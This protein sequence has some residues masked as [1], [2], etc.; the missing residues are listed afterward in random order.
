MNQ[1]S[2]L[3]TPC[4]VA[5]APQV[6]SVIVLKFWSRNTRGHSSDIS[7]RNYVISYAS[8]KN[9][10]RHFKNFDGNSVAAILPVA[11]A[12]TWINHNGFNTSWRISNYALHFFNKY[13]VTCR[14]LRVTYRRGFG[15][16]DWIYWHIIRTARD[17]R[18]YS[19]IALL[20]ILQFRVTHTHTRVPSLH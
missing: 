13:I 14:D 2:T 1:N 15:L 4:K 20:H 7:I 11:F 19:A 17:Y 10:V 16:D 3:P 12:F 8:W 5:S 6:E 9:G 18:Q